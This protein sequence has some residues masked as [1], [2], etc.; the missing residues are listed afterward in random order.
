LGP[1]FWLRFCPRTRAYAQRRTV[2]L[3]EVALFGYW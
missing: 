1:W 3:T 2:T